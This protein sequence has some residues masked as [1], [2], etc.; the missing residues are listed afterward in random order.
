MSKE[1]EIDFSKIPELNAPL[2]IFG[3]IASA[4]VDRYKVVYLAIFMI[5]IL[6]FTTYTGLPKE[7]VP[8]ISLNMVYVMSVY[9]GATAL[10][11]EELV[12]S[13]LEDAMMS[14]D[15]V[16]TVKSTTSNNMAT[17]IV[18]VEDGYDMA[19]AKLELT[20]AANKVK[21]PDNATDPEIIE[22]ATGELPVMSMTI[23]GEYDLVKLKE[24]AERLETEF[25]TVSGIKRVDLSGGYDREIRVKVDSVKAS[26][27]GLSTSQIQNAIQ[28]ANTNIPAGTKTLDGLSYNIRIDESFKSVE[29]IN[30]LIIYS[31]STR[32]VF[33]K[34]VASVVDTYK[35]P[36]KYSNI[37]IR[38]YSEKEETHSVVNI[39][40]YRESG[41]DLVKP[42]E[43]IQAIVEN[44]KGTLLP[45]D[46]EVIITYDQ[47]DRVKEDLKTV[48]NN[49][50]G[51][52][53][54]VII[55][56]FIFI[57]LNEALIVSAV[58][59]LS[60]FITFVAMKYMGL[61]F[62]TIS[63]TG[64]II[65]LGLLVDN[66][67]VVMENVDRLRDMKIDRIRASKFGLNQVGPAVF[68]ASLTT[69]AAFL[70][71]AM[72][73]G[74]MGKF[75]KSMPLTI[76]AIILSSLAVSIIIT[77]ALCSRF[78][79]KYK[80][81]AKEK[82]PRGRLIVASTFIFVL[83]MISFLDNWKINI[84]T[85]IISIFFVSLYLFRE[86][87]KH[88]KIRDNSDGFIETYKN[89]VR[90][91]LESKAKI[92]VLLSIT[93]VVF[94]GSLATIPL[95]ILK[96]ELIPPEEASQIVIAIEAPKGTMLDDTLA[97]AKNVEKH[98][99]KFEDITTFTSKI[100]VDGY[101]TAEITIE[102]KSVTDRK[103]SSFDL[104]AMIRDDI[105]EVAGADIDITAKSSARN[106]MNGAP[107]S[108]TLQGESLEEL[109][110]YANMY[111]EKLQTIDGVLDPSVSFDKGAKELNINI[112]TNKALTYGLS[113]QAISSRI[114]SEISGAKVGIYSENNDEIDINMYIN[115]GSVNSLDE[116]S[117]IYFLNNQGKIVHLLDIAT[118]EMFDGI[119]TISHEEGN[120][121][122]KIESQLENGYNVTEVSKEFESKVE[123]IKLP[124]TVV[125]VVSGQAQETAEQA[126]NM[127][128]SF[129]VAMLFVFLILAVQFNSMTQPIV[130]LVSVPLALI[131]A[132]L[133]LIVTGNNLGF[134]AMFGIVALV[135]IAVNDA[136]VLIDYT[137]YLRK[138]GH[139]L[140]EAIS[141]AVKTRFQP[142]IATSLTTIG[143]VLPLALYNDSFSQLGYSLIF[144]L[145]ASTVLTLLIIPVVYYIFD[146]SMSKIFKSSKQI[147]GQHE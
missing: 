127:M 11:I 22:I 82:H 14:V 65:A 131:G 143:G 126:A 110:K 90:N 20:N 43:D 86:Y 53:I 7:S 74:I 100:G 42:S 56:L 35:K 12:T 64:F 101:N 61:T 98:L 24:F 111:Y 122:V 33:L 92:A 132:F 8:D 37:F 34:D 136:I 124:S 13:P 58:I 116:L 32:V 112:D 96:M 3:K 68:A 51:G 94:I 83:S 120:R 45:S 139:E 69:V 130:I 71:V 141:E 48:V 144:G 119:G 52:L 138:D 146:K 107:I 70:P 67:I 27:Y 85:I 109:D 108:I 38:E 44:S 133:G 49:A 104:E 5:F 142:V 123:S 28:S 16:D 26:Q 91:L 6:G 2:N 46:V 73:P 84:N 59:P 137:N 114:R 125:K 78:L 1:K 115:E 106:I 60:M 99:Y 77:P 41:V 79:S 105:H 128:K 9:P 113:V 93:V 63:L 129:M 30:N 134:Y 88:K 25:K 80:E 72:V 66:A 23:T 4:F 21:L 97:I 89:F 19:L 121:I 36:D 95:G 75:L 102:I 140:K 31:D 87:L 135:G 145:L 54:T 57:G 29:D 81:D 15:G 118:I 103:L 40:I 62:N 55:V 18:T 50:L 76:I 47:S 117:K 10:D 147:G 17:V 39:D